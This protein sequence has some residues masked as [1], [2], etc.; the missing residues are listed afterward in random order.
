MVEDRLKLAE[1]ELQ[2]LS[3]INALARYEGR[4]ELSLANVQRNRQKLDTAIDRLLSKQEHELVKLTERLKDLGPGNVLSRGFSIL[5]G[6]AGNVIT[7]VGSLKSGDKVQAVFKRGRL[8]MTVD[9]ID[10]DTAYDQ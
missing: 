9:S 4:L 10:E 5:R 7:D 3:P 1:R 6:L 8:N 2:R